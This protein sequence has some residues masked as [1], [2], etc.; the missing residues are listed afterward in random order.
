MPKHWFG[1]TDTVQLFMYYSSFCVANAKPRLS[2]D[3]I[4]NG[5]ALKTDEVTDTAD[6]D[7][8]DNGLRETTEEEGDCSYDKITSLLETFV[9]EFNK[10]E[11]KQNVMI[12]QVV[13][14]S[15]KLAAEGGGQNGKVI[16][17]L[18]LLPPDYDKRQ[19][20]P[21]V[22]EGAEWI[23]ILL[24]FDLLVCNTCLQV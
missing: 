2:G 8:V 18:D 7:G 19:F 9:S 21:R 12:D 5:K 4:I 6:A 23:Y 22:E 13:N 10:V 24:N 11:E 15:L 20:P 17:H 1:F 3:D 14:D 16:G